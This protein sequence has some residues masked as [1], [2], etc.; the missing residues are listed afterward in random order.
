MSIGVTV[1]TFENFCKN[2]D[3]KEPLWGRFLHFHCVQDMSVWIRASI[4]KKVG[5]ALHYHLVFQDILTPHCFHN[6]FSDGTELCE[7][8]E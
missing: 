8:R 1:P 7:S 4:S 2:D 5:I 3:E 6:D